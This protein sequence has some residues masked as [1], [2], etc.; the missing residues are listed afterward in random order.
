MCGCAPPYHLVEALKAQH[1]L[2][3]GGKGFH[4]STF[5]LNLSRFCHRQTDY[6]ST[7]RI[8]QNVCECNVEPKVDE[9][10]APDLEVNLSR[11]PSLA[12]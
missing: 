2:A 10:P 1:V 6:D 9:W 7:Q 4:S 12:D 8:S 3:P 5:Q 11:F